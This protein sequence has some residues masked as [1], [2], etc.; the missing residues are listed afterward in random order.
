M[1]EETSQVLRDQPRVDAAVLLP[2]DAAVLITAWPD[3]RM[4]GAGASAVGPLTYVAGLP[5]F[6]RAVLALQRGGVRRLIVL[7]GEEQAVCHRMMQQD[8]RIV[9][10]SRWI[11]I[12]TFPLHDPRTWSALADEMAGVFVAVGPRTVLSP[13]VLDLVRRELQAGETLAIASLQRA[14]S[15]KQ[16]V[17][18][19]P[20]ADLLAVSPRAIQPSDLPRSGSPDAFYATDLESWPFDC[21]LEQASAAGRL[22]AIA[23]PASLSQSLRSQADISLAEQK[24]LD[25]LQRGKA[26]FEGMV[27]TYVNRRISRVFTRLFLKL[28]VSPNTITGMSTLIGLLAAVAF[29]FGTYISGIIG[30]LLL[31]LSAIVDCCDGEVARITFAESRLGEQLD[32][33]ADNVVHIALFAGL[34][35]GV[36]VT[37]VAAGTSS[38]LPL[39]LGV[40]AM[41]ANGL[42]LWLVLRARRLRDAGRLSSDAQAAR[43]E[44]VLKKMANRDFSILLIL[45][46][47]LNGLEWFLWLAAIGSN[48]FWIVLA[49]LTRPS[50]VRRTLRPSPRVST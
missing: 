43:V 9:L 29:A 18:L 46:A 49:W 3:G 21:L 15:G 41:L 2:L 20:D 50:T 40:A 6:L 24:L 47:I 26:E 44:T 23:V 31:Q 39:G 27:D 10:Q 7:A 35:W 5:L 22:R 1:S 37:Q 13:Q 11:S 8:R 17:H 33:Y 4:D 36:F 28:R 30:A 38:L 25:S 48:L 34:A 42:S 14:P 16:S 12:R 19:P 32:L 45:F